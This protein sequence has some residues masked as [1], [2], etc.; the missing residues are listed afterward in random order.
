MFT[1]A[2]PIVEVMNE[3]VRLVG[4]FTRYPSDFRKRIHDEFRKQKKVVNLKFDILK[5]ESLSYI[6]DY[7]CRVLHMS[8]DVFKNDTLCIEGNNGE[9]EYLSMDEIK[10][11]LRPNEGRLNVEVVVLAIPDCLELAQAFVD[12][13]VPHVI[14]FDFKQSLLS[15]FMDNIYTLPKRYDYIYDFCVEFYKGLILEKTVY[16]AWKDAKPRLNDGLRKINDKISNKLLQKEDV[17]EGPIL[18]P[19]NG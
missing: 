7:G 6:K 9:I 16:Q 3:Y 8:S 1:K 10:K 2:F 14:A 17:G 13:G 15:T 5:R 18:F 4:T 11:I 12:L 19:I